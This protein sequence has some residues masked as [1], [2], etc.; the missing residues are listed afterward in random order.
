MLFNAG[1]FGEWLYNEAVFGA[2][3][4]GVGS[5]EVSAVY[6][7]AGACQLDGIGDVVVSGNVDAAA[8]ATLDGFGLLEATP[9][10][11]WVSL[12]GK[13]LAITTTYA[14]ALLV[15]KSVLFPSVGSVEVLIYLLRA[16]GTAEQTIFDGA[17]PANQNLQVAVDTSARL[18]L[19]YGT[20]AGTA[21]LTSSE[22]LRDGVVYWIGFAWD[23]GGVALYLD[24][25]EVAASNQQ[26]SIAFGDN[27]Y[28][29]AR[30][31]RTCQLDGLVDCLRFSSRRRSVFEF[32]ATYLL[33]EPLTWDVDTTYLLQFDDNLNL[34]A[35]RQGVWVSP[36][37]DG[38]SATDQASLSVGW[39]AA[40]PPQTALSCQVR[41]S[42]DG[43][44]WSFWYDQVNNEQ[45]A[46]PA[47][48]YSQVRFI[49]QTLSGVDTPI[50]RKATAFYDGA[51]T[52]TPVAT[53]LS[54]ASGYEFAQLQDALVIT[55]GVDTPKKFDGGTT[56]SDILAAPS[57]YLLSVWRDR[58]FAARTATN[59]S[60]LYYSDKFSVDSWPATHFIDINP[61]DGDEIIS[62]LSGATSLLII[63]Q[64][65]TYYVQGYEHEDFM[66]MPAGEG[67]TISRLGAVWTPRGLFML[68]REG[69][70]ATDF[71]RRSKI[72]MDIDTIWKN[73]DDRNLHKASLFYWDDRLLVAAPHKTF[74][75]V[76]CCF[77]MRRP[78]ER[79]WTVWTGW[80]PSCFLAFYERDKWIYV[81][82]SSTS[83]NIFEVSGSDTDAG[84]PFAA[85]VETGHAP[86][87]SEDWLNRLKW[88]D[89]AFGG[90]G[91]DGSC[92]VSFVIDGAVTGPATTI[93]VP[94]TS[95]AKSVRLFPPP[96]AR[97]FGVRVA[98]PNTNARG[99]IFLGMSL[100]YFP[101]AP[102]PERIL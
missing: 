10:R 98:W 51:P 41:T 18:T 87:V 61:N 53:G 67:G 2:T 26:H 44:N 71:R 57:A 46:A 6:T 43:T 77:D 60:R 39:Q 38:R 32:T 58:V 91:V 82:G 35:N 55:N 73:L 27:V 40:L 36:V 34:P 63:K 100:T 11:T 80:T 75:W 101:R 22:T 50:L 99:P 7:A 66:V 13:A 25:N 70:W 88:C 20:G 19:R 84:E 79:P 16:P 56:T 102:R 9:R 52:M 37:Q 1:T 92:Q 8:S 76:T 68:D 89:L 83:G 5:L 33:Q 54:V 31:D 47:N 59:R 86:L 28:V 42:G 4:E 81:F 12:F 97:T 3:L 90:G 94:G 62:L 69:V 21:V 49:L 74:G 65:R 15:P 72:T 23:S 64:H 48:P 30:A 17:G 85:S 14:E 93:S 78:K 95:E 45:S 96:W 24:G 29:G